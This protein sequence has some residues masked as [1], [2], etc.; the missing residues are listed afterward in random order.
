MKPLKCLLY[1]GLNVSC[2]E[3]KLNLISKFQEQVQYVVFSGGRPGMMTATQFYAP[4]EISQQEGVML[5]TCRR[6]S[7]RP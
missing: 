5:G 1:Q 2:I 7:Q 6:G 4:Q 3:V